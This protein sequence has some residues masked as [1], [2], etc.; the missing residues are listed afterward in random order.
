MKPFNEYKEGFLISGGKTEQAFASLFSNVTPAT[1]KQN[2]YEH[3]DLHIGIKVEIKGMRKV[4]RNDQYF[5]E[6][7][8]W[9]ELIG[10][11]GHLGW[12]YGK[13]DYFAFETIDYWII[14]SRESL[15]KWIPAN[16]EKKFYD[17]P[18]LYKLYQTRGTKSQITLVKSLD[19]CS[20][21]SAI[22]LKNKV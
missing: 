22:L 8:H 7:I 11:Y 5:D 16:V 4:D 10:N 6:N 14:V 15:Q 13:A 2:K 19:L 12:V 20:I 3:W 1:L 9:L 21:S 18:T 17:R